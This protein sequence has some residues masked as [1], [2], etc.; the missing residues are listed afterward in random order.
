MATKICIDQML[1]NNIFNKSKYCFFLAVFIYAIY[2]IFTFL[3]KTEK[4]A[5]LSKNT[6]IPTGTDAGNI[7]TRIADINRK[8][9]NTKIKVLK[10]KLTNF[11]ILFKRAS[12][13]T[14]SVVTLNNILIKN[15]TRI[16]AFIIFNGVLIWAMIWKSKKTAC[17]IEIVWITKIQIV[18]IKISKVFKRSGNFNVFI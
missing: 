6:Q 12:V 5:V 14:F 16:I 13:I 15:W 17:E 8:K 3:S 4:L 2:I 10:Y 11:F 18:L 1:K 9:S 7:I